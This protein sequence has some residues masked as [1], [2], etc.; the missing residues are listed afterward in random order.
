MKRFVWGVAGLLALGW[1]ATAFAQ[2]NTITTACPIDFTCAFSAADSY[3]LLT[4]KNTNPLTLAGQ[5]DVYLGYMVFDGSSNVT[6]TGFQNLNGTPSKINGAGGL[7][8]PCTAG[9]MGQPATI[10]LS[11]HSQLSFVTDGSGNELQFILTMDST[12]G[13]KSTTANSVRIGT[14]RKQ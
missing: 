9:S 13:G 11:D 8:G 2:A 10:D 6:L 12:T 7:S 3:S 5:P 4:P 1:S 14:C